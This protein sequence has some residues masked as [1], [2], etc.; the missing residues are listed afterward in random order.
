[1]NNHVAAYTSTL[2]HSYSHVQ[3]ISL[4]SNSSSEFPS[5]LHI[6]NRF[7]T[8]SVIL[9]KNHEPTSAQDKFSISSSFRFF[10]QHDNVSLSQLVTSSICCSE[11]TSV[12]HDSVLV[13]SLFQLPMSLSIGFTCSV[14]VSSPIISSSSI[15]SNTIGSSTTTSSVTTS[16]T[17]KTSHTAYAYGVIICVNTITIKLNTHTVFFIFFSYKNLKGI[18]SF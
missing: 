15:G 11:F 10:S 2:T 7:F 5:L 13:C 14:A 6:P 16:S 1:M 4:L 18:F 12:D 17:G 9:S 3:Y 8:H